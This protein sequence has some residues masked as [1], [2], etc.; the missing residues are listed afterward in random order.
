[1][2]IAIATD[3]GKNIAMHFGRCAYFSIWQITDGEQPRDLGVRLNKFTPHA[4]QNPVGESGLKAA[5]D[6][7]M[8][9]GEGTSEFTPDEAS[10][11]HRSHEGV[12]EGLSDVKVVITAGM[13]RRAVDALQSNNKEIFVTRET[14]VGKAVE[15]Y[16][17]GNLDS[18]DSCFE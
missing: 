6:V 13:G 1:M 14:K 5:P 16:V 12:L 10:G 7:G 3:D 18:G 2:L 17:G 8:V 9:P 4:I 11:K 15:M